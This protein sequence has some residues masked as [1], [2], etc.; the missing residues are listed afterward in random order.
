MKKFHLFYL[1]VFVS[2]SLF[3]Q[4]A[5]PNINIKAIDGKTTNTKKIIE[6]HPLLVMTFW[7][8]WCKPCHQE[9]NSLADIYDEW[10]KST[11]VEIV[12]ISTDDSRTTGKVKSVVSGND[13]PFLVL[14]DDNNDLKRALNITNIPFLLIIKDGKIVHMNVGYTP[15]SE[16]EIYNL[17]KKYSN[18]N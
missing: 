3:G 9:L 2:S 14:L 18:K 11:G 7:A 10:K 8:T 6:E 5:F 1:L 12:A 16:S 15:G 13:W 4:E 17:L